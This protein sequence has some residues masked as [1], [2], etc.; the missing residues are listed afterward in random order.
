VVAAGE[1]VVPSVVVA[2]EAEGAVVVEADLVEEV[3]VGW[4][5]HQEYP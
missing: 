3:V 4:K 2:G 1:A 5:P